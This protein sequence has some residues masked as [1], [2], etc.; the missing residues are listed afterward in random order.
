MTKIKKIK[1]K[2]KQQHTHTLIHTT[3]L[4]LFLS[5]TSCPM[6]ISNEIFGECCSNIFTCQ[7][8]SDAQLRVS[9]HWKHRNTI[10]YAKKK[11]AMNS[12]VSKT[13]SISCLASL[14]PYFIKK[15]HLQYD[16]GIHDRR[17]RKTSDDDGTSIAVR[18]VQ[19]FTHLTN[20]CSIYSANTSSWETIKGKNRYK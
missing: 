8:P 1:D 15:L 3:S 7:V 5:T 12:R 19:T 20:Q 14:C 13:S 4:Q 9:K 17:E 16:L 10:K 2:N 11:I 18:E 6:K